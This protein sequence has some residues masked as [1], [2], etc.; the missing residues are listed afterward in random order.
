MVLRISLLIFFLAVSRGWSSEAPLAGEVNLPL[1]DYLTLVETVERVEKER[2]R[3]KAQRETPVAEVVSQR[4]QVSLTEDDTADVT[5]EFEVLVQGAPEKPVTLPV[6]GVPRQAEVKGPAGPAAALT[7]GAKPGEWLLVAPAPGRYAVR[8][9]GPVSLQRQGVSRLV[10]APVAAPVSLTEIDLPADLAWSAP[11][12]VVVEDL[13]AGARRKVRLTAKRG[14]S[15]AVEVRRKVD[16]GEADQLLAQ[17]LVLTLVQLQPDGP[18]RH[19]VILYDVSRGGL[20]G[21]TVD[22]PPGLAVDQVGTDE[23]DV[24]PAVESRRLTV[25]R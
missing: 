16:G 24:V 14:Q 3:Q 11:G 9:T 23:G 8:L 20:G 6:T 19:D 21:F 10:L 7:A 17:T 5:S 4:V 1:K 22:L 25:H 13:V 18:R 15:P 12:S 2:E